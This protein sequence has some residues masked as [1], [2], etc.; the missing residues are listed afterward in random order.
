MRVAIGEILSKSKSRPFWWWPF[1]HCLLEGC[2]K[3]W[4][5]YSRWRERWKWRWKPSR[6][7]TT[8]KLRRSTRSVFRRLDLFPQWVVAEKSCCPMSEIHFSDHER[9]FQCRLWRCQITV[10]FFAFPNGRAFR[11]RPFRWTRTQTEVQNSDSGSDLRNR[12]FPTPWPKIIS[13]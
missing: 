10:N 13:Q 3:Q 11:T 8:L 6:R 1:C 2:F 4:S 12:H 9:T 5:W 7:R